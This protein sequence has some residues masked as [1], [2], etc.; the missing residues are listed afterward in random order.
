LSIGGFY[1]RHF[2][3]LGV[4]VAAPC[5]LWTIF[6]IGMLFW[7]IVS[8]GGIGSPIAY[9]IGLL[10]LA[11]GAFVFGLTLL[12]PSTVF[13]E[14]IVRRRSLPLLAQIPISVLTLGVLCF[15]AVGIAM[16]TKSET[17]FRGICVGFG[18][19][20]GALLLPLGLYWWTAQSGPLVLAVI[21]RVQALLQ[22]K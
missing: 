9:P 13:A 8:G 20:F 14:W 3:A 19:L 5:V 21:R 1:V 11:V 22:R 2:L 10:I 16:A 12:F 17:T 4:T 6:Y 7:A 18:T 15:A